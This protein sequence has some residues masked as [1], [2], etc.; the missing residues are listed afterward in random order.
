MICSADFGA[1][2]VENSWP[3][4]ENVKLIKAARNSVGLDSEARNSS[5]MNNVCSGY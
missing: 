5:R 2:S 1:L 4:K 3:I